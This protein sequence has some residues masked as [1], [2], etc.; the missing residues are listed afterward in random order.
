MTTWRGKDRGYQLGISTEDVT[1]LEERFE[2]AAFGL[3]SWDDAIASFAQTMNSRT[4]QLIG[5]GSATSLPF[6]IMTEMSPEAPEEF[7]ASGGAD[8][9]V[10]SRVR[11]G[12][13]APELVVVDDRSFTFEQDRARS[14]EFGDWIDRHG[15]GYTCL[16]NLIKRDDLVIGTAIIRDRRQPM[17]EAGEIAVFSR[18][19]ASLRRAIHLQ[20]QMEGQE[21]RIVAGTFELIDGYVFICGPN[22]KLVGMSTFAER[23]LTEGRWLTL[24]AGKLVAVESNSARS[25]AEELAL[26]FEGLECNGLVI[27]DTGGAPLYLEICPFPSK[28]GVFFEARSLIVARPR[29]KRETE[30]ATLA[31]SLFQLTAT[32]ARIASQ[33]AQGHSPAMTAALCGIQVGTVRTHLKRIFDKTG[34]RGQTELAALLNSY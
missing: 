15:V 9:W 2:D 16:S 33:I 11:L 25:L 3:V 8:P 14:P 27:R 19:A 6:N 10:N 28:R 13:A 7:V 21:A 20:I 23:L 29:R 32:E 34:L 24:H 18:V 4:G 30:I 5:L 22:G 31:R 12:V 17:M 26:K 1:R